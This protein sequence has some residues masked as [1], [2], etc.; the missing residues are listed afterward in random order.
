MNGVH[1]NTCVVRHDP[2]GLARSLIQSDAQ[3]TGLAPLLELAF[4]EAL[5]R[6]TT[7][8][9]R[10]AIMVEWIIAFGVSG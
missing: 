9:E 6:A 1:T 7:D 5:D 8:K 2:E 4:Q 3:N 10:S